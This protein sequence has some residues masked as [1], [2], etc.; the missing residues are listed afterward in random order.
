[1]YSSLSTGKEKNQQK[2]LTPVVFLT[3]KDR[4]EEYSSKNE[5]QDKHQKFFEAWLGL[6]TKNS[7]SE[8]I[9]LFETTNLF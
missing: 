5:S 4:K 2:I 9:I 3:A 7:S 8:K 1:M 6:G